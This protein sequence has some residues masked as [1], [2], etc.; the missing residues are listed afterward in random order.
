MPREFNYTSNARRFFLKIPVF[1]CILTQIKRWFLADLFLV[2]I[3]STVFA[4]V[5]IGVTKRDAAYHGDA[6]NTAAG[7]QSVCN[8]HDKKLLISRSLANH[9]H[10]YRDYA[11]D[12]LAR[13][14]LKS[15]NS[16]IEIL[17]VCAKTDF[18]VVQPVALT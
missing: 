5:E 14:V 15:K 13:I 11:V 9:L 8:Q 16:P 4:V 1:N 12:S 10:I 17:N 3:T 18:T 6:L 2:F 7:I